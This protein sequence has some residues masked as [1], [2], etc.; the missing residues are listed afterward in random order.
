[1]FIPHGKENVYISKIFTFNPIFVN[2]DW[3]KLS[4][5]LLIEYVFHQA[6][7]IKIFDVQIAVDTNCARLNFNVLDWNK[8]ALDFYQSRGALNLTEKE[9]WHM[10]RVTR[11]NMELE[12]N[13]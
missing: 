11:E 10:L 8:N 1:M 5:L 3:E 4:S 12:L 7:S 2:E 9:G 13:K 6:S